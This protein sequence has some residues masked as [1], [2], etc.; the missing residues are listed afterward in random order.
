MRIGAHLDVLGAAVGADVALGAYITLDA[1]PVTVN[2]V[3]EAVACAGAAVTAA[4]V[5]ALASKVA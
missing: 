2:V 3:G 5:I 4:V 1:S